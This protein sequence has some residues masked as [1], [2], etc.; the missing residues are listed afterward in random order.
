MEDKLWFVIVALGP[1]LLGAALVYAMRH[2]RRLSKA[3]KIRQEE[4]V[5]QLYEKPPGGR[6]PT[7]E[8]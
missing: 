5:E 1:V 8:Q 4:A 6:E 3:E 7:P 2:R